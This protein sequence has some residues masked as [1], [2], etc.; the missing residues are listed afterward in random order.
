MRTHQVK[1]LNGDPSVVAAI[2][3][4]GVEVVGLEVTPRGVTIDFRLRSGGM[5][6]TYPPR[7]MPDK[8]WREV[9]QV[10]NDWEAAL[11]LMRVVEGKHEPAREIAEK[12]TFPEDG[13][14]KL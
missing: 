1:T 13:G 12:I 3:R 11:E 9:Y 10:T 5:Y 7:P 14:S 8:V 2:Q 6:L 4:E